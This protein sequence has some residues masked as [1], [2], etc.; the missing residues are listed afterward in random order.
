MGVLP[1][2]PP[3]LHKR[4]GITRDKDGSRRFTMYGMNGD[5]GS[6]SAQ[7]RQDFSAVIGGVRGELDCGHDLDSRV[8]EISNLLH[9]Q[10]EDQ[11][12]FVEEPQAC[13]EPLGSTCAGFAPV[14]VCSLQEPVKC[15]LQ[16]C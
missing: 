2:V 16:P 1:F 10:V 12:D 3:F 8:S 11:S 9:I 7:N 5:C 13:E 4:L 14:M 15:L 6:I